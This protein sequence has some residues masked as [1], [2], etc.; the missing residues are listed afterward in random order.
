[1]RNFSDF[2]LEEQSEETKRLRQAKETAYRVLRNAKIKGDPNKIAAAQARYDAALAAYEA[3]KLAD[4]NGGAFTTTTTVPGSPTSTTSTPDVT[5]DPD[6]DEGYK[7]AMEAIKEAVKNKDKNKNQQNQQNQQGSGSGNDDGDDDGDE[8]TLPSDITGEK[9]N[10]NSGK[11][12]QQTGDDGQ[13]GSQSTQSGGGGQSRDSAASENRGVVRPEDCMDPSRSL[14]DVPGASGGM[15]SK[16]VGDAIA[17]AEGYDKD[18]GN[19]DAIER[20][21]KDRAEQVAREISKKPGVGTGWQKLAGKIIGQWTVNKNWMS[22]LKKLI[23]RSINPLDKRQ[24]FANK[25]VLISQDRIA[26]TDKD[27]Y[28]NID[29]MMAW[30]D[31]SGSMTNA[32]LNWCINEA[33]GIAC[34]IKPLSIVIVQFDSK[35][36]DIQIYKGLPDL[37]KKLGKFELKGGGGTDVK[38]CF[39]LFKT[40]RRFK[41]PAEAVMIFT[42]GYLRQYKRDRRYINNLIWCIVGNPTFEVQFKDPSTYKIIIPEED[43][44]MK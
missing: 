15:I 19:D 17:D 22:I 2:I 18:G 38:E 24:A 3:G 14:K 28:D 35:I 37:K 30:I 13:P 5:K 40:D 27:K 9:G 7:A 44:K 4:K 1:M 16:E 12:G 41:R 33:Y 32:F 10:S 42:D 8:C 39:D 23:G 34:R 6:F 31:T 43:A 11:S 29:Y 36:T 20:E 25:N 26:R 21:W